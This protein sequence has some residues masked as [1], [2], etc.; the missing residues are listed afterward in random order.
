MTISVCV[1]QSS[2]AATSQRYLRH[3]LVQSLCSRGF[4]YRELWKDAF[5]SIPRERF[6]PNFTI[7]GKH[8]LVEFNITEDRQRA[9]RAL[10]SD[11]TLITQLGKDGTPTSLATAPSVVAILLEYLDAHRGDRVLEIGTGCGYTTALLTIGLGDGNVYTIEI[12][13]ALFDQA[14]RALCAV[15][16]CPSM[17]CGDGADGLPAHGSFDRLLSSCDVSR[18][19]PAWIAQVKPG[20]TIVSSLCGVLAHLTVS[21]PGGAM[22]VFGPALGRPSPMRDDCFD[23]P[24]TAEDVLSLASGEAPLEEV[25]FPEGYDTHPLAFLRRLVMPNVV[26]VAGEIGADR[27]Y[28]LAEPST[29][30][31]ARVTVHDNGDAT[32]EQGG[33]KRLWSETVALAATWHELSRPEPGDLSLTVDVNGRHAI[34]HSSGWSRQLE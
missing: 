25:E 23:V 24:V 31:W 30:S 1:P 15:D 4:L 12:H 9:L 2:E 6:I 13:P 14:T 26:T 27:V 22:G 3:Q 7:Q 32:A 19:P 17:E 34:H 10:Y 18:V 16:L 8:G 11:T 21:D 5:L 33:A 28:F 20:G 29:G